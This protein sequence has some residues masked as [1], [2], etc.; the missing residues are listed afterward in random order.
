MDGQWTT[1]TEWVDTEETQ[2]DGDLN[3]LFRM[4]SNSTGWPDWVHQYY[5]I[6]FFDD[7]TEDAEDYFQICYEAPVEMF[8]TLIGGAT[9]QTDCLRID[10]VGHSQS[11]LTVYKGNG[12]AWVESTNY[13]WTDHIEIVDSISA[14]PSDSNPHLII[15]IKIEHMHFEIGTPQWLRLAVYDESNSDAGVQAWPES[16]VNSPDE[17]GF[18]DVKLYDTLPEDGNETEQDYTESE[19]TLDGANYVVAIP[20]DWN[21]MLVV[22][23][24]G[25]E[26]TM[27]ENP[28]THVYNVSQ[29][30]W[31]DEGYA[32]A[33]STYG[34]GGFCVAEGMNATYQLTM[35]LIETY[36]VTGKVFLMG[37]SLGGIIMLLLAEK[38][39]DV[40]SGAL[41]ITGGIDPKTMYEYGEALQ[42]MTIAEI[43]EYVDAPESVPDSE[44]AYAKGVWGFTGPV[45]ADYF[46]GTP[47]EQP[48]AYEDL[49]PLH[50]A[51][52]SV[53]VIYLAGEIDYVTPV[54]MAQQY[55][56]AV[57]AAG[58][59]SYLRVHVIANGTHGQVGQFD[60][61]ISAEI[62]TRFDE[63]VTWADV[64][65]EGLTFGVMLLLSTV[66]AI[67]G[68]SFMRKQPKWKRW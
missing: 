9:P 14:S 46:G 68:I 5:L 49:S 42:G 31:L 2:M 40:Y 7:T 26:V 56:E 10:F 4:K 53:P 34:A 1:D 39:P 24:R 19:G 12:T 44:L 11:G 32:V 51:N 37:T 36:D 65:P 25:L 38:Y 35:H 20:D 61:F 55:Q 66:A 6:E 41:S 28:R 62:P 27:S 52:I 33:G 15:E 59:S 30:L 23:C 16:S 18:V 22:T 8:G 13:T 57:D 47:A 45:I 17:W 58:G 3:V 29:S 64:I 48:E 21:G 50:H 60:E 54:F 63:L 43:R 67:V